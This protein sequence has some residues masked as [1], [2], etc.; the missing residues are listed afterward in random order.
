MLIVPP[1]NTEQMI[2]IQCLDFRPGKVR[3]GFHAAA[4]VVIHRQEVYDEIQREKQ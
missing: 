1:S 2:V 4:N 3:L